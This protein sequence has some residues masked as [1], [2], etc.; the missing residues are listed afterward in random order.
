MNDYMD[1][2]RFL[3]ARLEGEKYPYIIGAY[4]L[5]TWEVVPPE[6]FDRWKRETAEAFFGPD[7]TSYDYVEAIVTIPHGDLNALFEAAE[8]KPL[9]LERATD[10]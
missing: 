9:A 7:W 3:V 5:S 4:P 1:K 6:D 2:T 8:I 10:E